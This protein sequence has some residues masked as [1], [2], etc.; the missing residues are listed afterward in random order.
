VVL[1]VLTVNASCPLALEDSSN[2]ATVA[3][4]I[5]EKPRIMMNTKPGY[6]FDENTIGLTFAVTKLIYG[7]IR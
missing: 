3:A 4:K 2:A 5:I 1:S 6:L 7:L